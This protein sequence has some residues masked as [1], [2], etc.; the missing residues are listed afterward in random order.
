MHELRFRCIVQ[1]ALY[2]GVS[3][4]AGVISQRSEDLIELSA[5]IFSSSSSRVIEKVLC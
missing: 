3:E 2:V 5:Q 4:D 1:R